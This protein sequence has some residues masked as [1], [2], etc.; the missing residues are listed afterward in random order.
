MGAGP[1]PSRQRRSSK[2]VVEAGRHAGALEYLIDR[3][4]TDGDGR[5]SRDEHG[6]TARA[7][8][9]LDRNGDGNGD[10]AIDASDF[11]GV[12][13]SEPTGPRC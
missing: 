10:G 4:D 11:T 7:F 13:A 9:R 3:Y 8:A 12:P 1:I 2:P 5:V 6:R